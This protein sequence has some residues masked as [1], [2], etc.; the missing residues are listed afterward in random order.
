[1]LTKRVW[2]RYSDL[3]DRDQ[4]DLVKAA[5]RGQGARPCIITPI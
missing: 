1:M 3:R 5:L 2:A 4:R